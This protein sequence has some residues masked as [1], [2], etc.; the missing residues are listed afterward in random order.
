MVRYVHIWVGNIFGVEKSMYNIYI[1]IYNYK[2]FLVV[3]NVIGTRDI[4]VLLIYF[5]CVCFSLEDLEANEERRRKVKV[6]FL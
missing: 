2:Y 1:L 6:L 3:Q 4:I 5:V